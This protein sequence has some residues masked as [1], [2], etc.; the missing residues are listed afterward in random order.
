MVKVSLHDAGILSRFRLPQ[1]PNATLAFTAEYSVYY[2]SKLGDESAIAS[3]TRSPAAMIPFHAHFEEL[4]P[5]LVRLSW[6]DSSS[7]W[8]GI[9]LEN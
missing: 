3:D 2:L 4:S 7:F 9:H 5:T 8:R 6:P 1:M